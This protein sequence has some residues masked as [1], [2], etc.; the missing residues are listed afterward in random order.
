MSAARGNRRERN[1]IGVLLGGSSGER[2]ISLKSGNA[3][4]QS[5]KRSGY[6]VVK[7][8]PKT[9]SSRKW[10]QLGLEAAFIAL[11]GKG[12]EDGSVQKQLERAKIPYT[13]SGSQASRVAFD[14][15]RSKQ[16]FKVE[17][18]PTPRWVVVTP[19]NY[20]KRIQA[21]HF[22]VFTKPLAEGSSLGV[23]FVPTSADFNKKVKRLFSG[24]EKLLVEEQVVGREITVGVLQ[25]KA[26][27]VIELKTKRS[28][29]DYKAKYTK[30]LTQYLVPAP[31]E[32]K[33]S[34]RAKR[35]AVRVHRA[36]KLRDFSRVDM[37][38]D[39]NNNLQVLEVNTIPG[40]TELSLLPKAA[41]HSGLS[42]DALCQKILRLAMKRKGGK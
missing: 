37:M 29:Y 31:L 10:S 40:F 36:L 15:D 38:L 4:Y 42:F 35:L 23:N 8:D 14:K 24:G 30:G 9:T 32:E 26:L 2:P 12:G 20:L 19:K 3:I 21:L 18:I 7:V 13:G 17:G 1:K 39:E 25:D 41:K 27:S 11:H 28:F 33:V 5:L 16:I 22:P 34:R 6:S